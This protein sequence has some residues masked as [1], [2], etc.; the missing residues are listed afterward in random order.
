MVEFFDYINV[1]LN[2]FRQN[3]FFLLILNFYEFI[4][5]FHE[6]IFLLVLIFCLFRFF[7]FHIFFRLLFW[8]ISFHFKLLGLLKLRW[9]L[10]F[11]LSL[12]TVQYLF[13]SKREIVLPVVWVRKIIR[14]NVFQLFLKIWL[15]LFTYS[16]FYY[17]LFFPIGW[18]Y[19][20]FTSC[21]FYSF[22]WKIFF[23]KELY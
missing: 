18:L 21:N 11:G 15:F 2:F 8:Y 1:I 19:T 13:Q 23:P 3:F 16:I 10:T 9:Y 12:I 17:L 22:F 4:A 20:Y 7:D 14:A 5:F 6:I